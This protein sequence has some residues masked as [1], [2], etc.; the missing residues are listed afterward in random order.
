MDLANLGM[1]E[2]IR[3]RGFRVPVLTEHDLNEIFT[4]RSMLEVPAMGEVPAR[5]GGKLIPEF[6]ELAEQIT[7]AARRGDLVTFLDLDRR[8]HLGLLGLLGNER[9]VATVAQLR[10]QARMHGLQKLADR[11]ELT[12]SGEEHRALVDAIEANDG[13]LAARLMRRHLVHSR[14]IWAGRADD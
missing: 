5:L 13:E 2:I 6:R 1:V 14:G 10:D 7:D 3:N 12:E 11:G 4:L 8:F 9:L